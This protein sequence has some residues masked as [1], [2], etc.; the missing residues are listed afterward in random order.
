MELENIPS[1][2][3]M[4]KL[5]DIQRRLDNVMVEKRNDHRKMNHAVAMAGQRFLSNFFTK[6]IKKEIKDEIKKEIKDE[7]KEEPE[8]S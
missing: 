1:P 5:E 8:G 2:H 3:V 7:I 4:H 6:K